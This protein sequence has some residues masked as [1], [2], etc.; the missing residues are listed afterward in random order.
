M[1]LQHPA[2]PNLPKRRQHRQ[3]LL[4]LAPDH[5]LGRLDEARILPMNVSQQQ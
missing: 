5:E 4:K 3:G 2:V 1:G